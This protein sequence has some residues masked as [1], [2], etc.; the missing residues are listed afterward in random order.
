MDAAFQVTSQAHGT[1][2][3]E[4]EIDIKELIW[5]RNKGSAL[6]NTCSS[7]FNTDHA[8][9]WQHI[10][11]RFIAET[12]SVSHSELNAFCVLFRKTCSYSIILKGLYSIS[13]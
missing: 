6:M 10:K 2:A 11:K 8:S 5:E 3:D 4:S 7:R 12:S 9:P 13:T 1:I